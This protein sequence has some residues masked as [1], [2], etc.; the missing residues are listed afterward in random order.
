MNPAADGTRHIEAYGSTLFSRI[1]AAAATLTLHVLMARELG[2]SGYAAAA[3]FVTLLAILLLLLS[4]GNEAMLVREG[5]LRSPRARSV[6]FFAP[7]FAT[8]LAAIFMLISPVIERIFDIPGLSHMLLWGLPVL[9]LQ[10]LQVV[11]RAELLRRQEFRLLARTDALSS[12]VAWLPAVVLFILTADVA[13]LALYL[14]VMHAIRLVVYLRRSGLRPGAMAGQKV[15]L[16]YYLRSW[17]ILSIDTTTYLTTSFDDLMVAANLGAATLGV[18]HLCYRVIVVVQE[19]FAGVMRVLSYPR[20]TKAAPD[21]GR[22]YAMFCAD[23]RF[24]TA[25]ILPLL[26]AVLLS[27]DAI[28]PLLLGAQW[29]AAVIVFQLLTIEAMRQSLLA[30]GGQALI[31]LK[32][33]RAVLR[34]SLVSA[35]VL[36]PLFVLLSFTDLRTFVL[37]FVVVNSILNGYFYMIIRRSFARPF[38]PLLYAWLPGLTVSVMLAALL[39]V[40]RTWAEPAPEMMLAAAAMG[41]ALVL[42]LIVPMSP[43]ILVSLRA[44]VGLKRPG[45]K[46]ADS[47]SVL[48]YVDGPFDEMNPHLK[49]IYGIVAER[50]AELSFHPLHLRNCLR[51]RFAIAG[52]GSPNNRTIRII[53]VHYPQ[54]LYDGSTLPGAILRGLRSAALL[55][56]LR[57]VGYR[58]VFTLHDEGAHDY[59]WRGWERLFLTVLIHAADRVTTLSEAGR[60]TLLENFGYTGRITVSPHCIYDVSPFSLRRRS[61]KRDE[62]GIPPDEKTL[63]LFGTAKPYKGYRDFLQVC[64]AMHGVA[65]TLICAGRGMHELTAGISRQGLRIITLDRFIG[66]EETAALMDATDYGALPYRRILHSGTAMLFASHA[67]PVIAPRIGFFVDHEKDHYVGLYC[68]PSNRSDLQRVIRDAVGRSRDDF[69]SS[70]TPFHAAHGIEAEAT[71][72]LCLYREISGK[73]MPAGKRQQ[74]HER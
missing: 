36:L 52:E 34:Y 63:L 32:E 46:G 31:A 21:R 19:F 45:R 29:S 56:L 18:Y 54:H 57:L 38:R 9:P 59:R 2:P 10:L 3:L 41:L 24:V 5:G 20:Y 61:E 11:P 22:V 7:L 72:L 4:F 70:F 39:L 49:R 73:E 33:E 44:A 71:A 37:G 13:A 62:L 27:A 16:G 53:H 50:A 8:L 68:T 64:A 51:E 48:V 12:T 1:L 25:I 17:R 65:M 69:A 47:T 15:R 60:R 30:L 23:T 43:D 66:E 42:S 28:V 74:T 26:T 6:A 55:V 58:F 14:F 67:C 40:F 35:A